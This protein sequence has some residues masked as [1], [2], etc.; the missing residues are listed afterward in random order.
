MSANYPA[1]VTVLPWER[2]GSSPKQA[3]CDSCH[4][5][6]EFNRGNALWYNKSTDQCIGDDLCEAPGGYRFCSQRCLSQHTYDKATEA[7]QSVLRLMALI[8]DAWME[9][10]SAQDHV[11]CLQRSGI[12]HLVDATDLRMTDDQIKVLAAKLFGEDYLNGKDD[13]PAWII[14]ADKLTLGPSSVVALALLGGAR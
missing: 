12:A 8:C 11:W 4:V 13:A 2:K 14:D 3:I 10:T 5:D 9:E 7:E 1:G 6:M